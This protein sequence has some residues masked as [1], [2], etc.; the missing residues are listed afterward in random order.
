MA[1]LVLSAAG[2]AF[3]SGIGGSVVGLSAMALGKAVGATLGSVIDQ[4]LLGAGS[5]PV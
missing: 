3:G 2:A 5:A 1:T 4:R